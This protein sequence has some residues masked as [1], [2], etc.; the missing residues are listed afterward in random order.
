MTRRAITVIG[1]G[2]DGCGS[3][4]SRARN[5]IA[6]STVLVGGTRHLAFF[7][8]YAGLRVPLEGSIPKVLEQVESLAE[9]HTVAILASGDPL[10]FG[11]GSLVVRRFG[12][13]HVAFEPH[14]S[15]MQLAFAR[16]GLAWQDASF[17]SVHGRSIDGI[18]NRLADRTKVLCLT[19]EEHSPPRIAARLL[20]F[21]DA[22]WEAWVAEDLGSPDE[23]VRRFTLAE[24]AQESDVRPLNVLLLH[25][26]DGR[27]PRVVP[28]LP[29]EAFEKRT[30]KRGLIT[31][32][33]VRALS[34]SALGL[35][36][37]GV[38]WDIGTGSGSVAIEAAMIARDGRGYAIECDPEGVALARENCRTHGVDN[39]HVIEGT[40]P[41]ALVGL[42]APDGVF[43]G[44]SRGNMEGI[45]ACAWEALRPGGRLVVNAITLENVAEAHQAFRRRDIVPEL[46]LLSIARGQ[47]L[48]RYLRYE[49]LNPVHVFWAEKGDGR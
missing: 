45:V 39:V 46:M 41:D 30:P 5:R 4:T 40:A 14:P 42:E 34:L 29:E 43:V 47:K 28:F 44:G 15:A 38:F 20:E 22:E 12:A 35:R 25:R 10:F 16:V 19:D 13:A 31:K 24:L 23:R 3:L 1:I 6:A 36:R 7:P 18:V 48:A 21:G 49:S 33:E 32:R 37:D 9:E 8:E 2:A 26:R 17:V 27:L 11:I